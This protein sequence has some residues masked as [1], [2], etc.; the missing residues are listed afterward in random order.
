MS[1]D[2]QVDKRKKA[3]SMTKSRSELAANLAASCAT[4]V[5][6][7]SITNPINTLKIRWQV[8]RPEA[9]GTQT[10]GS[11]VRTTVREGV[12]YGLWQPGLA[13]GL[14]ASVASIG[15]RY[16]F[17]PLLRDSMGW[18]KASLSGTPDGEN[19]KIGATGMFAAGLLSGCVGYF[20][21]SPF[22]MI[23][24]QMQAEAGQVGADGKYITGAKAGK[25]PTY[26]GVIHAWRTISA[27]GSQAD[28]SRGAVRALWRGASLISLRGGVLNA[29]QMMGYDATKTQIKDQ[30]LMEEGPIVHVV[31]SVVAALCAT[32]CSMPLDVTLSTYQSA[33][34]LGGDRKAKYGSHGPLA[35]ARVMLNESGPSVFMR[36]W[37]P[38]FAKMLPTCVCSM[39]MFEQFRRLAGIGYLD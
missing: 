24:T 14:E 5:A 39:W 13:P 28:G 12:W 35:C 29:S 36:G 17:Y 2:G 10:L 16:G 23:M 27:A 37:V 25:S 1:D 9:R 30:K 6:N 33:Q 19:T 18:M 32:T 21:A 7:I 4:G 20:F 34:T 26:R 15:L 31:A 22:L 8:L 11:F 3:T 38:M